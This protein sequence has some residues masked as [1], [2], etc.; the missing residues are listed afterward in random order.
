MQLTC[1][2]QGMIWM[3][4]Q[5]CGPATGLHSVIHSPLP[6]ASRGCY[7]AQPLLQHLSNPTR[8]DRDLLG[9]RTHVSRQVMAFLSCLPE[10]WNS[11]GVIYSAEGGVRMRARL[12]V[13]FLNGALKVT[14]RLAPVRLLPLCLQ[15][16]LLMLYP[17]FRNCTEAKTVH[18]NDDA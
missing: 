16:S 5:L 13:W 9:R 10:L 17:A 14:D 1:L 18:L 3:T 15:T 6:T 8:V 2:G 11:S 4:F 12:E 7:T